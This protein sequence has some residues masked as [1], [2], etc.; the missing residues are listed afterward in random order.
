MN[1]YAMWTGLSTGDFAILADDSLTSATDCSALTFQARGESVSP[2]ANAYCSQDRPLL[3][4]VDSQASREPILVSAEFPATD[5]L[6]LLQQQQQIMEAD[7]ALQE[8]HNIDAQ[9]ERLV[10][11][12]QAIHMQKHCQQQAQQTATG[13][14]MPGTSSIS[15]SAAPSLA[16]STASACSATMG[17]MDR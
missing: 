1:D 8:E 3:P 6:S 10:Q 16:L 13:A 9:I 2:S 17:L 4:M 5:L 15:L 11:L 7:A 12:K 14:G